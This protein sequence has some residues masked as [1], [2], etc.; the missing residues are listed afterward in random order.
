MKLFYMARQDAERVAEIEA[1]CF[2]NPWDAET[3]LDFISAKYRWIRVA[4]NAEKIVGHIAWRYHE[5]AVEI[6]GVAVDPAYRR[7]GLGCELVES[8]KSSATV[9]RKRIIIDLHEEN[10]SGQLFFKK[11]GFIATVVMREKCNDGRDVFRLEWSYANSLP[12]AK[13]LPASA[14]HPAGRRTRQA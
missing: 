12:K 7:I 9:A 10:L 1:A 6:C 13:V 2:P 3:I 8:V 4:M 5:G 11:C 14:N